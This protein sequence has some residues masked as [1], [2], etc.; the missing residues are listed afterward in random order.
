MVANLLGDELSRGLCF[1]ICP[2][3]EEELAEEGVQGF[4]D[5]D[6][7]RAGDVE[8]AAEG[9]EEPSQDEETPLFGVGFAGWCSKDGGSL[10][11]AVAYF[12]DGRGC[13]E[14]RRACDVGEVTLYG[15]EEL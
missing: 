13:E 7:G 5:A 15:S 11:P 3:S 9:D 14:G 1:V 10:R 12:D 8:L 6:F 2:R 4:L